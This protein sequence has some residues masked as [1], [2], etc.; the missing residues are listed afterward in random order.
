MADG[1]SSEPSRGR[2]VE[3][4]AYVY[5]GLMIL[6]GSSTAPAARYAV[7]ELPPGFLPLIRYGVAGLC[8]MP[9][10]YGRLGSVARLVREDGWRL[11]VAAALSVPVNQSFF[12]NATRLT[13][14]AHVALIYAAVP[15]VVV[16]LAA[17]LGQERLAPSR[18]AGVLASVLG[19]LVIGLDNLGRGGAAGRETIQGDLLLVGAVLSWGAYLIASKP[20]IARHG[21][22]TVLAATFLA[23]TMLH[24]PIALVTAPGWPPLSTATAPAWLGLAYLTLVVTVFGLACQNLAMSSFDASAVAT[25]GN[26]AP[27]LTVLWGVLLFGE[28]V[29]PALILGGALTLGGVLWTLRPARSTDLEEREAPLEVLCAVEH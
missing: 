1:D 21:A 15:L 24:A 16:L 2:E 28:T 5:V 9:L 6:I 22:L 23:G 8:L 25:F 20:L 12:L 11:L 26:A 10:L 17:A 18:L 14:T 19:V 27:V 13:S 29:T 4:R 7:R 3:L